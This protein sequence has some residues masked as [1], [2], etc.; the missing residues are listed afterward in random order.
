MKLFKKV[1]CVSLAMSM[2]LGLMACGGKDGNGTSGTNNTESK[3]EVSK[4][5][6]ADCTFRRDDTFSTLGTKGDLLSFA[7]T[8][9]AVYMVTNEQEEATASDADAQY[10]G[11]NYG[12]SVC[13]LYKVPAEGGD[14]KVLYE[15]EKDETEYVQML[16]VAYDDSIYLLKNK[17]GSCEL[18]KL[19]GD[20]ET[21]IGDV[22]ALVNPEDTYMNDI[23]VD[24]D[25]NIAFVYEN[26]VKVVDDSLN[27]KCT[28]KSENPISNAGLD[29]D[30][31][32]IIAT[33][34][35]SEEEE[36]TKIAA[37]KLDVNG[38][39][40]SNEYPLDTSF[41]AWDNHLMK[42]VG[43]YDFFY[44]TGSNIYGY[45]FDSNKTTKFADFGVSGVNSNLLKTV[46]MVGDSSFIISEYDDATYSILP[47]LKKFNKVDPS[48]VKG[49]HVFTL[50]TIYGGTA[51]SQAAIDYNESQT[52][53][54]VEII[55]YSDASDPIGKFSADLA[56]GVKPDF[57]DVTPNGQGLSLRQ[58]IAKGMLEELTPYLEKDEELSSEDFVPSMYDA[59]LEDGKLYFVASSTLINTIVGKKS[60]I[61]EE[62]G[63]SFAE[64]KDYV[65]SK[66][67]GTRVFS[68]A[69]KMDTL[70]AFMGTCCAEFVD[71]KAGECHFDSQD[72]KDLLVICN[73][74]SD[75]EMDWTSDDFREDDIPNGIQ[76]FTQGSLGADD[77]AWDNQLFK[78]DA[79]YKGYPSLGEAGGKF[80]FQNAIAMSSECSDKE[81]GWDFIRYFLTED[82]Q[83]KYYDTQ[84]GAPTR[85]DVFET[86]LDK[87][88]FT[89]DGKDKY[90]NEIKAR[91]GEIDLD[92]VHIDLKPLKDDEIAT[93]RKVVETSKGR[94]EP[95]M[96]IWE[97]VREEA[98]AY[99]A[100]DK[101]VDDVCKVIQDRVTTYVNESK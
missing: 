19:E 4:N 35:Y 64:M 98:A 83:G 71:W 76:L 60:E 25:G 69:N 6:L 7:A 85:A 96:K 56:S 36:N 3:V 67:E 51:I 66:P 12:E 90:G 45:N 63:W 1:L 28:C 9:D 43:G 18:S 8:K 10:D 32:I 13:R 46:W 5:E 59:M 52:D 49:K 31:N 84:Y 91:K 53:N 39:T 22:T 44:V 93:F 38:G 81:A 33:A 57:Y 30:G 82:Y 100:G 50:A 75:E 94:W 58:Y 17:D 14:A 99:F 54:V 70:D 20:E 15:S 95:D 78:G 74:G 47:E 40:L 65:T 62:P 26:D 37:R 92:G 55:D 73:T 68:S 80:Y 24:K 87:F 21:E 97:I 2:S 101:S 41:L 79:S 34:F 27:E 77:V 89:K 11:V 16:I 23:V 48:E 88:T 72:F 29:K 42:G 86:Y 61:G